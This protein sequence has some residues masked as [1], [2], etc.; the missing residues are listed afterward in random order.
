M[1]D[2][3]TQSVASLLTIGMGLGST[4]TQC[5]VYGIDHER[6]EER[7]ISTTLSGVRGMLEHFPGAR[8]VMEALTLL[9]LDPQPGQRPWPRGRHRESSQDP[10]DHCQH[11]Q[12]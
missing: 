11:A 1:S 2:L 6:I 12:M 8:I 4:S 9:A 5:A 7:K 10:M 3:G